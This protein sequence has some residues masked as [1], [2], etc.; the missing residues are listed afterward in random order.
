M[1]TDQ[2]SVNNSSAQNRPILIAGTQRSGTSMIAGCLF[3]SG[4]F[5]GDWFLKKDKH[6]P[7]GYFEDVEFGN[8]DEKRWKGEIKEEEWTKD[9]K[10]LI[11]Q[12]NKEVISFTRWGWKNPSSGLFIQ[13]YIEL[14]NPYVIWCK[15][16]KN[17]TLDSMN[18]MN[19]KGEG[20]IQNYNQK[21]EMLDTMSP[22]QYLEVRFEDVIEHPGMEI[23]RILGYINHNVSKVKLKK[24]FNHIIQPQNTEKM[25]EE[26][27]IN[28][29]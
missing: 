25:E 13:D 27:Y 26:S 12:R 15:R 29:L 20:A 8:L 24:V 9:V 17:D 1:K 4:V 18:K 3:Y 21:I 7:T 5:M 2:K 28:Y 11:K 19:W 22:D 10:E 14:C 23:G 16:D 6:N